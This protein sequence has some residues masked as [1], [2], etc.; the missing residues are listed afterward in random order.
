MLEV[1]VVVNLEM[2]AGRNP[3]FI[4]TT[5]EKASAFIKLCLANGYGAN[6]QEIE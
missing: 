4:F 1:E 5:Y 6:I 2:E 3:K